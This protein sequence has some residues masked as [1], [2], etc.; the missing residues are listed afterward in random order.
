M[1]VTKMIY[2]YPNYLVDCGLLPLTGLLVD[3]VILIDICMGGSNPKTHLHP[4]VLD[5]LLHHSFLSQLYMIYSFPISTFIKKK[6]LKLFSNFYFLTDYRSSKLKGLMPVDLQL[7]LVL[8]S[9]L[10]L[11][12]RRIHRL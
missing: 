7:N 8:K 10:W 1:V 12:S 3:E 2:N 9:V 5:H 4:Y 6:S 11:Y